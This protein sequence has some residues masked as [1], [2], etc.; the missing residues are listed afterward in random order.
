MK[1][2]LILRLFLFLVSL[3]LFSHLLYSLLRH[4]QTHNLNDFQIYFQV[5]SAYPDKNPYQMELFSPY[6]YP[7]SA[8][9]FFLPL[10]LFP[11]KMAELLWL[12]TLIF[13]LF[14][15]V[16]ILF[17][18]FANKASFVTKFFITTLFLRTFPARFAL[19]LGQN[20][21][22]ILL[23]LILSFY[24]YQKR[25]QG[26]A[27]LFLGIAGAIRLTP[28]TLLFFYALKK[29]KKAILMTLVT[30][31]F[32]NLLAL[33]IFGLEQFF[34]FFKV[35]VPLLL[36]WDDSRGITTTYVNQSL[37]VF[38]FRLGLGGAMRSLVQG[39]VILFFL[40][41]LGKRIISQNQPLEE[42][43]SYA[44]LLI[45]TMV[46][47]ASF[48]WQHHFVFL[49]PALLVFVFYLIQKPELLKSLLLA[50][51]LFSFYFHFKDPTSSFLQNPILGSHNFLSSLALF[52]TLLVI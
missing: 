11:Y 48:C 22:I 36:A 50:F 25:K 5:A 13:S 3:L 19:V 15:I 49:F 47:I 37:A 41:L 17:N 38:L 2:F 43:K 21:L 35:I 27:G 7:S 31:L 8:T 33:V 14:L 6:N 29:Q 12:L 45:L 46:F 44:S 40:L 1:I 39:L 42:F 4:L 30:F 23:F 52:I 26:W 18:L 20:S 16:F 34:Y 51:F 24:F 28:L 32:F 9:T 10:R